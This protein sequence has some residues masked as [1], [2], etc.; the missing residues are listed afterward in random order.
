MQSSAEKEKLAQ[1]VDLV[2]RLT[3]Q[4]NK[5][6]STLDTLSSDIDSL[7]FFSIR[8]IQ[9]GVR[10]TNTLNSYLYNL[11]IF[12]DPQFRMKLADIVDSSTTLIDELNGLEQYP[13]S[14]KEKAENKKLEIFREYRSI[15]LSLF[16]QNIYLDKKLNPKNIKPETKLNK[17]SED[18]VKNIVDAMRDEINKINNKLEGIDSDN[19]RRR[20]LLTTRIVDLKTRIRDVMVELSSERARQI[21]S[22]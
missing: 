19:D 2:D 20:P 5:L 3:L 9:T 7:R 21:S 15:L 18:S 8:T 4:F 14:E 17:K 10:I 1:R 11:T 6:T 12:E 22:T 13:L 16:S